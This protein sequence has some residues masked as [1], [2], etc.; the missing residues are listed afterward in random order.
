LAGPGS[1]RLP[2]GA[3]TQLGKFQSSQ[4]S[5]AIRFQVSCIGA[6]ITSDFNLLI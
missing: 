6:G 3:P 5:F 1:S 4:N 2:S